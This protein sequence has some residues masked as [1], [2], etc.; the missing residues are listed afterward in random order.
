MFLLARACAANGLEPLAHDLIF[1]AGHVR[2]VPPSETR[3]A[4]ADV[5]DRISQEIAHQRMW[6]AVVAFGDLSVTRKELLERFRY[7][8]KHFPTSEHLARAKETADL[9][10]QMVQEDEAHA[11]QAVQPLAKLPVKER[12]AE[13]VFRLRDQN[14]SS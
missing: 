9:L 8:I 12:V 5:V 10:A 3:Q 7:L 11:R 13:L 1:E 4:P 6:D 14:G 2:D